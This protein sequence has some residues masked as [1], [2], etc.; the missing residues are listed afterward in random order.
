MRRSSSRLCTISQ[1]APAVLVLYLVVWLAA[2]D[3]WVDVDYVRGELVAVKSFMHKKM[4]NKWRSCSACITGPP[5]APKSTHPVYF[6]LSVDLSV[7]G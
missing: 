7:V 1:L 2:E 4:I 6:D 3:D 5:S